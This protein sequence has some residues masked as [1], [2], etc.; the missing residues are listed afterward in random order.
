MEGKSG[1][2]GRWTWSPRVTDGLPFDDEKSLA[3]R[4]RNGT[5]SLMKGGIQISGAA[6]HRRRNQVDGARTFFSSAIL[7]GNDSSKPVRV[8][9][10]QTQLRNFLCL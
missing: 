2:K 1:R 9:P 5:L 3:T 4:K 7:T 8:I 6:A 10:V